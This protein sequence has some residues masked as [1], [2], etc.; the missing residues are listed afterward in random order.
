MSKSI[1]K[2]Y[3][4]HRLFSQ[5]ERYATFY[6]NLSDSIMFQ[7]T[8]YVDS[9]IN[10]DTFMFTSIQGTLESIHDVLLKG[11]F[12]DAYTLLRKY[13]DLIIINLYSSLYLR[14]NRTIEDFE[15]EKIN[16]W[17]NGKEKLPKFEIMS[18]FIRNSP[19]VTEI[20]KLI[21]KNG[22]YN[23]SSI[24][25]IRIRCNEYTHYLFY[26][27][28]LSNDNEVFLLNRLTTL[29]SF[30]I[31]LRTFFIMHFAYLF[32]YNEAYMMSSDYIDSLDCG[33]TPVENSQYWVAPFI[34]DI[35]DKEIKEYRPDIAETIKANTSMEL[36]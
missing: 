6:S 2:E 26:H 36:L 18:K 19:K 24:E 10:I 34:Q 14:E 12:S 8:P 15:V 33:M 11:R 23:G 4:E 27:N 30:S 25:N 1:S 21:Y 22:N 31:D 17:V 20:T 3:L 35:F 9:I 7:I 13:H 28:L 5:I 16:N 29:E 32:Y